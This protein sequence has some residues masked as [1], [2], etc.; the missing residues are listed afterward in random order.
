LRWRHPDRGLVS[1]V[2][3]ISVAEDSGL[4][5]A[6]GEYALRSACVQAR[7]WQD[8]GY[9]LWV[10]VNVSVQQLRRRAFLEQLRTILA[11]TRVHPGLLELEITESLIVEDSSEALRTLRTLDDLGVRLA[12]DDFGTGYS[13]L[14]YLKRFPIDTVKIDQSFIRDI[15][16]DADDAAIVRAIV[17][18]AKSLKLSVVAEGVETGEQLAFLSNLGCDYAQG[19]LLG[20]PVP[21]NELSDLLDNQRAPAG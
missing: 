2:E 12:I 1:P 4:I 17:G 6:M 21:A 11:A 10:S 3:F 19:Y 7:L 9:S 8:Q 18:M 16:V 5:H 13:G 14:S 15:S 20:Y